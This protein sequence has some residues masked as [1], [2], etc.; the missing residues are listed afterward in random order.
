MREIRTHELCLAPRVG[1]SGDAPPGLEVLV[2]R[3]AGPPCSPELQTQS[4]P[5]AAGETKIPVRCTVRGAKV[6]EIL[7]KDPKVRECELRKNTF[8][9]P[10]NVD[11][12]SMSTSV[13]GADM[14][15][16]LVSAA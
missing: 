12:G 6:G 10:G 9:R 11:F 14:T 1:A 8:S 15:P 16:A 3:G 13:R 5:S 7:E 2:Q 4:G